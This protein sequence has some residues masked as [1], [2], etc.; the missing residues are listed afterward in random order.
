MTI[1]DKNTNN[2][3]C[4]NE[5][6]GKSAYLQGRRSSSSGSW[7]S[8]WWWRLCPAGRW[9]RRAEAAV[10]PAHKTR[11]SPSPD[12][13]APRSSTSP[14]CSAPDSCLTPFCWSLL[15]LT[16]TLNTLFY[17]PESVP[18]M[19]PTLLWW[20]WDVL[21]AELHDG[22]LVLIHT[23]IKSTRAHNLFMRNFL[24]SFHQMREIFLE[25]SRAH[26]HFSSHFEMHFWGPRMTLY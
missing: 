1:S 11:C 13:S 15:S 2:D 17:R 8:V 12:A 5:G 6:F 24:L 16:H 9:W 23:H 26:V 3:V 18:A 21:H 20:S 19:I 4:R 14:S 7:W 10:W 22:E 25:N